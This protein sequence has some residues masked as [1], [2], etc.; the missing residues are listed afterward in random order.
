MEARRQEQAGREADAQHLLRKLHT[1]QVTNLKDLDAQKFQ[2]VNVL[3]SLVQQE[4]TQSSKQ[5]LKSWRDSV[6]GSD[7][8]AGEWVKRR[9]VAACAQECTKTLA[10]LLGTNLGT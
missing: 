9:A 4:E 6:L 1:N 2:C 5:H 10:E 3:S 7:A 8:T